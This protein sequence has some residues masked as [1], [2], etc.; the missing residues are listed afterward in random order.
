MAAENIV[1]V[2]QPE[3]CCLESTSPPGQLK[4]SRAHP[5]SL[6]ERRRA[7]AYC[8]ERVLPGRIIEEIVNN[9]R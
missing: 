8:P 6:F 1:S 7:F 4:I 2:L 5:I 3:T 9:N